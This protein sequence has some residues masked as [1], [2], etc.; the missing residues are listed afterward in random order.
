VAISVRATSTG[1]SANATTGTI[2]LPA[3]TTTGDVTFIAY[4]QTMT[5]YNTGTVPTMTPPTGWTVLYNFGSSV[6]CYRAFQGG[7]PST[8]ITCTSTA[9]NWWESVAITYSGA[10]TTTPIDCFAANPRFAGSGGTFAIL[11]LLCRAPSLNPNYNNSR[12]LCIF[13][14]GGSAG[15]TIA[16]PSGLTAQVNTAVGPALRMADKVLT[17]GTPT[18]TFDATVTGAKAN[19]FFGMSIVVK[20]S[21]AA[22]ATLA[23]AQPTVCGFCNDELN[24]STVTLLL[25]RLNVQNNDLVVFAASGP[26]TVTSPPSGYTQQS[27][28]LGAIIYTHPWLTG[29][30]TAP[31]FT[32]SAGSFKAWAVALIRQ[33][34][35][36]SG[37]VNQDQIAVTTATA[38]SNPTTTTTTQTPAGAND[39]LLVVFGSSTTIA[40]TW[41]AVTAGLTD[42]VINPSGPGLRFGWVLPAASPTGT[43]SATWTASSGSVALASAAQLIRIGT[44]GATPPASGF[45]F[46][47]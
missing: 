46:A 23:S 42:E 15:T 7:D 35:V 24:T 20:A 25:D 44:G 21:G 4:F 40:G 39:L 11:P 14:E 47:A 31:V 22:A 17:D 32:F 26:D 37:G 43:F 9:T 16:L 45:L 34:G 33:T 10:D 19:L 2:S 27:S 29:D 12:L 8:G 3:G 36:G 28:Q 30:T 6:V 5:N 41:S 38:T 13:S 1:A 18:G